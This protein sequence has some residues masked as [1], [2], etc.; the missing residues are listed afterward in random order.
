M[1]HVIILQDLRHP[2]DLTDYPSDETV[3]QKWSEGREEAYQLAEYVGIN[4]AP[5]IVPRPINQDIIEE[6]PRVPQR[7]N[8]DVIEE[9]PMV[10]I[11]YAG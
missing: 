1:P 7:E 10:F 11:G 5:E 6:E 8:E 9:D 4:Q 3:R 2:V